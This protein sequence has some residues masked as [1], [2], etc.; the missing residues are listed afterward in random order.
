MYKCMSCSWFGGIRDL[1]RVLNPF[2]MI[3]DEVCPNCLEHV[4]LV[5][6]KLPNHSQTLQ[7]AQVP[8]YTLTY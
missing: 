5:K 7:K 6:S 2:N 1:I 4:V 8:S 3:Q